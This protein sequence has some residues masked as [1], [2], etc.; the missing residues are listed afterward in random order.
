MTAAVAVTLVAVVRIGWAPPVHGV[1]VVLVAALLV[2]W[3][4]RWRNGWIVTVA[5]VLVVSVRAVSQIEELSPLAPGTVSGHARI[6]TDPSQGRFD[7]RAVVTIAGRRYV[8]SMPTDQAN[9]FRTMMA[10]ETV[11]LEG[12]TR[13]IERAPRGWVLS[14][15]LAGRLSLRTVSR[16]GQGAPWYRLANDLRRRIELSAN[17]MGPEQRSLYLGL[18]IGDDRAQSE[19]QRFRFRAS[20]LSHVLAVSGQNVAFVL[21]IASPLLRRLNPRTALP[22]A[23]SILVVFVLV[24]RAE[25]SILRAV[26]MALIALFAV[27]TGREAQGLRVLSLTVI[28]LV[29][30]DPLIVHSLGF[31]LS[32]LATLGLIVIAE[33]VAERLPG[34]RWFREPLAVTLAAQA[35]T[36]P[37]LFGFNDSIP[38]VAPVANLLAVPVAGLVM[39]AGLTLGLFAGSVRADLCAVVMYPI[40]W[41]VRWVDVVAT[42]AS[43]LPLA[44][45]TPTRAVIFATA[46]ALLLSVL[47]PRAHRVSRTRSLVM[48]GAVLTL[49]A[50][51]VPHPPPAGVYELDSAATVERDRCGGTTVVLGR[52][53]DGIAVLESLDALHV[54]SVQVVST[55]GSPSARRAASLVL[56]QYRGS[57]DLTSSGVAAAEPNR[58]AQHQPTVDHPCRF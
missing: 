29:V 48:L 19:L 34:P 50:V 14:N 37:L 15:H 40:Q 24:T 12:R 2:G 3:G 43:R 21:M 7:V 52:G 10:G 33:P 47:G 25:P 46:T 11:F 1:A 39:M 32:V 35:A 30:V 16:E 51:V 44:P 22:V 57:R 49:T 56:R 55:D 53:S 28:V 17:S 5:L 42:T 41:M 27:S 13:M 58:L 4:L 8:A 18:V 45:L 26:V 20:G 23:A 6:V 38:S 31:Q 9:E 54:N 36:A